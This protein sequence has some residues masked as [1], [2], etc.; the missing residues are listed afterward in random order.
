MTQ[1][2]QITNDTSRMWIR[3][4]KKGEGSQGCKLDQRKKHGHGDGRG[5]AD[6]GME[7][8]YQRCDIHFALPDVS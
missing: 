3:G 4:E 8:S 2:E 7:I 5:V 6:I 1:V